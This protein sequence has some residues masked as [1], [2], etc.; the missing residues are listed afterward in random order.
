MGDKQDSS[1]SLFLTDVLQ[2]H[3]TGKRTPLKTKFAVTLHGSVRSKVLSELACDMGIASSYKD[4]HYL[5]DSWALNDLSKNKICPSELAEGVPSTTVLDN[6]DWLTEDIT[7]ETTSVNRTNMMYVQPEKWENKKEGEIALN[8]QRKNIKKELDDISAQEHAIRNY[9]NKNRGEPG[10][11]SDINI[12]PGTTASIRSKM[13]A[14]TLVRSSGTN[15]STD[16]NPEEQDIPSFTGF[17]NSIVPPDEKSK[18]YY[19]LSLPKAPSKAVVY[20]CLEKAAAAATEKNMPFIQVVGGQPVYTFIVELKCENPEKFKLILPVLGSF[21]IQ[22]SF[23]S[24][25]YKRIQNSNIEDLL[26]EAGLITNGSVNKALKGKNY[27]QALRLYKLYYEALSRLLIRYGND[28][29]VECPDSL[30]HL[31]DTIRDVNDSRDNR[32]IAFETLISSPDFNEYLHKLREN[33]ETPDHHMAKYVMSVMEMIEILFLNIDSLRT[34]DWTEFK[35]SLRL[36]MP[37]M[38]IYN[39]THYGRWL[40][41]FW[42]EISSLPEEWDKFMPDIFAQSQTGNPYSAIPPDLWI[43]TTMNR[44]SKLKAGWKYLLKND[45]GLLVHIRNMNNVNVVRNSLTNLISQ[46]KIKASGHK[47]NTK[48]RRRLDEKALQDLCA[49]MEEWNCNPFD[50]SQ[51]Q[52]RT[53]MSGEVADES[54]VLDFE[55]A[56]SDGEN[57]ITKN[58]KERIFSTKVSL[59]TTMPKQDRSTFAH[60]KGTNVNPSEGT[61]ESK[62]A[63]NLINKLAK[64]KPD[65]F[66]NRI[67]DECLSVFDVNGTIRKCNKAK[68]KDIMKFVEISP[69]DYIV[70]VD[71]GH[72]WRLGIPKTEEYVKNDGTKMTWRDFATRTFDT[73]V[74]RHPNAKSFVIVNDY[75][76][77]D[78]INPKDC[79][80]K[81]RGKKFVGGNSP[82]VYPVSTKELPSVRL[83]CDFF[84]NSANKERFQIFLRDEF[85]RMCKARHVSMIYSIRSVTLDISTSPSKHLPLYNNQKIEADNAMFY[86]YNQLRKS[87]DNS[88]VVCDAADASLSVRAK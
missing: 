66:E 23:M 20:T 61:M 85:A 38:A 43:E 76:G 3:I 10:A 68:T 48:P 36:M 83:L 6:D 9:F 2:S 1:E 11:Y 55:S 8:I 17:M 63:V 28:M 37:W 80:R 44:G 45:K 15:D 31:I 7:G 59:Y 70:I 25:I 87:G 5:Y 73:L 74:S 88:P 39:N 27:Y 30:H 47:E 35:N 13:I 60:S 84:K 72:M 52:L 50:P 64:E 12:I 65:I 56:Q 71:A 78:V 16:I 69:K 54:L 4:V 62:V 57:L 82:N 46:M 77:S 26:T 14:H 18:A 86:I 81:S 79:E 32:Y 19:F 58:F 41:I 42:T 75:Y 33:H 24:A 40:P 51:Q 49:L 21:H 67:T 53:M 34:K 22:M 29:G